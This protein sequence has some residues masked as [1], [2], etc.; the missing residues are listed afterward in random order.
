M[1]KH[2]KSLIV[3][4]LTALALLTGCLIGYASA[5][6]SPQ[7]QGVGPGG[8]GVMN[9]NELIKLLEDLPTPGYA[10]IYIYDPNEHKAYPLNPLVVP[11]L[12]RVWRLTIS[13][14]FVVPPG[15]PN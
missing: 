2:I 15:A 1:R 5:S 7:G 13:P 12:G 11:S 4:A 8:Q 14:W 6:S 9:K 3:V 10:R